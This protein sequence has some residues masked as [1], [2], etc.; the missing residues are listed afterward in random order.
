ML[1]ETTTTT[2]TTTMMIILFAHSE[3]NLFEVPSIV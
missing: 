3:D 1:E 2:T